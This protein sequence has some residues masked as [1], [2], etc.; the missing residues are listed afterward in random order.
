MAV[1]R[2]SRPDVLLLPSA[3]DEA[4]THQGENRQLE[5]Q[6]TSGLPC[7]ELPKSRVQPL[8]GCRQG[9]R[10]PQC[11][12]ENAGK[13][14]RPSAQGSFKVPEDEGSRTQ[15]RPQMDIESGAQTKLPRMMTETLSNADRATKPKSDIKIRR[16]SSTAA[17]HRREHSLECRPRR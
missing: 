9:R 11:P 2:I 7:R 15:I 5:E 10:A 8:R 12:I 1:C 14:A 17:T 16:P 4:E 13:V 6:M 3:D